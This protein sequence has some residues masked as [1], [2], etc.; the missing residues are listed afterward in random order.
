MIVIG[1]VISNIGA[2]GAAG[3]GI[4]LDPEQ[5]RDDLEPFSRMHG[6]MLKDT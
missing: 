2:R 4:L 5:A 1:A 6:G 3:S